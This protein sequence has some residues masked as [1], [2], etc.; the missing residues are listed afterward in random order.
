[1]RRLTQFYH[2]TTLLWI[3]VG[4]GISLQLAQYRFNRSL[5]YDEASLALNLIERSPAQLVQPLDYAQAAP[6]G[7]LLVEK[8]LLQ[9]FGASEYVLRLFPL[10]AGMLAVVLFLRVARAFLISPAI[11]LAVGLLAIS[12]KMIYYASELKPYAC[13]VWWTLLLY[14]LTVQWL[15]N[16]PTPAHLLLVGG[17]GAIAV[18]FSYP[19]VFVVSGIGIV[20]GIHWI[21]NKAWRQY[22]MLALSGLLWGVSF[23]LLY[24]LLLR[25]T[26]QNP[27]LDEYWTGQEGFWPVP[28]QSLADLY[29]LVKTF[30]ATIAHALECST[31]FA[32]ALDMLRQAG[33]SA[34]SGSGTALFVMLQQG[35]SGLAWLTLYLLVTILLFVGGKTLYTTRPLLLWLLVSPIGLTLL[36]SG[37]KKYPFA[38][39]LTL[40]F[41]PSLFLLFSAGAVAVWQKTCTHSP[42]VGWA[43]IGVLLL[44]PV[45]FHILYPRTRVELRPAIQY[46]QAHRQTGDIIYVYE[47]SLRTFDYYTF[48]YGIHVEGC[49]RGTRST[50][51]RP[52]YLHDTQPLRG[53]PRVWLLFSDAYQEEAWFL[54]YLDRIGLQREKFQSAGAA[55][56]LYDLTE[57]APP[58]RPIFSMEMTGLSTIA[59][60]V[61]FKNIGILGARIAL[62]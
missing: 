8:C 17:V 45:S 4:L 18:W 6:P 30:F 26:A 51:Q 34:F 22:Q 58:I 39:R 35:F 28:P 1:M 57:G 62:F 12:G 55:A 47:A 7:F 29:W 21:R 36:A 61:E 44:N 15:L 13:D 42:F 23:G 27:L 59:D 31:S 10:V 5:W 14:A 37:L 25:Q 19:A 48:L 16:Q 60:R 9:L 32:D 54:A 20:L 52:N 46:M 50:S 40:F 24:M 2:S 53:H 38:D 43:L 41:M 49:V 33:Q 11:P 56:Y 3:L